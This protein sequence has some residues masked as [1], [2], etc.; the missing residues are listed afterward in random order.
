MDSRQLSEAASRR[1]LAF[2]NDV[3][4]KWST[5]NPSSI[6]AAYGSLCNARPDLCT[7]SLTRKCPRVRMVVRSAPCRASGRGRG[8]RPCAG[9]PGPWER[10]AVSRCAHLVYAT[11][12]LSDRKSSETR[13]AEQRPREVS[14][15]GLAAVSD[16]RPM[17]PRRSVGHLHGT[18]VSRATR[19]RPQS[20]LPNLQRVNER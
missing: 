19:C 20:A 8:R 7:G 4:T 14:R 13:M 1:A 18:T 11:D 5:A 12:M 15:S 16:P 2:V 10:V 9:P 3:L 17:L 6:G